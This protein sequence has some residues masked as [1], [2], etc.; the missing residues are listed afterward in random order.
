MARIVDPAEQDY[1]GRGRGSTYPWHEWLIDG[2]TVRVLKGPGED[3]ET[4]T[5]TLRPQVYAAA[6]RRGGGATAIRITEAGKEGLDITFYAEGTQTRHGKVVVH[7]DGP[8]DLDD[9]KIV[10]GQWGP[11]APNPIDGDL[12]PRGIREN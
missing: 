6:R 5:S 1:R 4:D 10:H 8:E 11:P 9:N 3:Y 12:F 2:K 7:E